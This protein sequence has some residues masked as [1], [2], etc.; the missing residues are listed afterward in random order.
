MDFDLSSRLV[1]AATKNIVAIPC[2]GA[3]RFTTTVCHGNL[4]GIASYGASN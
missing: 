1:V 3:G 2:G 4:E